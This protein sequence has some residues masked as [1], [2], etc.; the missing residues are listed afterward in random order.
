MDFNVAYGEKS[1]KIDTNLTK[2]K[3]NIESGSP[4]FR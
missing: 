3:Y 2:F 4:V 1:I